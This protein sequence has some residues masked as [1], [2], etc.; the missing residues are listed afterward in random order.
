M[1]QVRSGN[2]RAAA[3]G[4]NDVL[5][6]FAHNA[7]PALGV[8]F[9]GWSVSLILLLYWL[10]NLVGS[11]LWNR[12][13]RRH[14]ALTHLR[15]HYRNQLGVSANNRKIENFAAEH[16][17]GTLIF[18][19][20]HGVF[21]FVFAF[22]LLDGSALLQE[23]PWVLLLAAGVAVVTALEILPLRQGLEQRSFAWLRAQARLGM[24]PVMAMHMG[25][26]FGGMA[27]AWSDSAALL[28]LLFIALRVA[29]DLVRV[30][31]RKDP[32][33]EAVQ[34]PPPCTARQGTVQHAL[35]RQRVAEYEASLHDEEFCP[36]D[37]RVKG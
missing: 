8:V 21:L 6:A 34:P 11:I 30:R 10:E 15:G 22:A 23:A 18:T 25:V 17:A 19:L 35:H 26:I 36:P 12:L 3:L 2:A 1:S 32:S 37:E 20:A 28:A 24:W 33:R 13:I 14:A 27:L 9:F 31:H 16:F 7:I 4:R 29:V 5:A